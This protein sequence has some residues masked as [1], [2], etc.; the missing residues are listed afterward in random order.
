MKQIE[1]DIAVLRLCKERRSRTLGPKCKPKRRKLR[2]ETQQDQLVVNGRR[3]L[4]NGSDFVY[5]ATWFVIIHNN[6]ARIRVSD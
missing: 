2:P 1:P 4:K 5:E 6:I 3:V